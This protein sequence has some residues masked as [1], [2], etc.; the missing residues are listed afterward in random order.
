LIDPIGPGDIRCAVTG[1]LQEW[2]FPILEN[3]SCLKNHGSEYHAYAILTMCRSLYVLEH[4]KIIS[5]PAAA[6]WAGEELGGKWRQVMDQALAVRIGQ[7][8]F[9]L[10]HE[11]LELIRYTMEQI[12]FTG[13]RR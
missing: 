9:D 11:S 1:I 13:R 7:E 6:R 8:D 4:G 3:P 12:G 5:K 10:Y 2:W